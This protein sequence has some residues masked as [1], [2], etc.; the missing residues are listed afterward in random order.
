MD[1]FGALLKLKFKYRETN[2]Y[3]PNYEKKL[4]KKFV[5]FGAFGVATLPGGRSIISRNVWNRKFYNS[6]SEAEQQDH[7]DVIVSM[8]SNWKFLFHGCLS[9][10]MLF[11]LSS[12]LF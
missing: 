6:S 2:E 10:N 4:P 8:K 1:N 11:T 5:E 7:D 9:L 12:N 3:G